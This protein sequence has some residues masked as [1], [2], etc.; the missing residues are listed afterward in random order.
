MNKTIQTHLQEQ[1]VEY[2]KECFDELEDFRLNGVLKNG[3]IRKLNDSFFSS[4][5]TSLFMIGEIVY[6]EISVRFFA[7]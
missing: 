4:N 7:K 6:R 1:S 5:P 2:L 3:E